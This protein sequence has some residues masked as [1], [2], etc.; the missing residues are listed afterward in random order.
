MKT[1]R[2]KKLEH[3]GVLV[4]TVVIFAAAALYVS[5]YLLMVA[6]ER[7]AVARSQQWNDALTVAEAGAEEA[8]AM[9]NQYA[10]SQSG[11]S[12]WT[13]VAVQEGWSNMTNYIA[14]TNTFQVFTIG[15][16]LPNDSGAYR[17]YLTNVISSGNTYGIP[18]IL[19]IGT[20]FN[21]FNPSVSRQ[22]LVQTAAELVGGGGGVVAQDG[23]TTSGNVTYDSW[24]SSD[25]NHS[26]WQSNAVYRCNYF[27][28]TGTL[29]G[30]WSNSLS[31][32]SNSYPSRT[33]NVYVFTDTNIVDMSGNA[34]I[35]GYL[36]T[37]PGAGYSMSG[38][39]TVGDLAWCFGANGTGGGSSGIESG[40]YQADANMN[41]HS[42]ALP[43][44][45]DPTNGWMNWSNIP[46]PPKS[47]VINIG[48]MWSYTNSAWVLIGGANYTNSGSGFNIGGNTYSIV[49]TNRPENTNWV[50]YSMDQLN[51]NLFVD[52]QYVVLYLTNGWSFSGQNVFTL[53]TNADIKIVTTGDISASGKSVINNMGNYTHAFSV[54][55]VA[56]HPVSVSLTGNSAASGSYYLPGST[57]NFSGGGNSG[58]FVGAVVCYKI[59]DSGGMNIHFDQSLGN[60]STPP[61]QFSPSSWT[62]IGLSD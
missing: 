38:N 40:H 25:P 57:L 62:E 1:N 22:V 16:S 4:L 60:V 27:N 34:T 43:A 31:Y 6:T 7:N 10:Y 50:Y 61:D 51:Q 5:A 24:D 28:P 37:G 41:F 12:N 48:G 46:S 23:V 55:D 30:T 58:D 44:P 36:Q 13:Q 35:A 9:V 33:A 56:G 19:S 26:I 2:R 20:A 8:L 18:V 54:Y 59:S 52:A 49:I 53:N 32:V 17:V 14:G 3:G 45:V 42:Y 21:T 39:S 29:Y 47:A 15:R 11:V